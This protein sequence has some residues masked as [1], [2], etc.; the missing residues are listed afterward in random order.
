MKV[1]LASP[2]FKEDELLQYK[3][4]VDLLRNSGDEIFV[5]QEHTIP[6]GEFLP[7]SEWA[8]QVFDMDV[9]ALDSADLVIVLNWGLYSD[10]GTAWEQGYAYAKGKR[11]LSVLMDETKESEYSLMTINGSHNTICFSALFG[12]DNDFT[13]QPTQK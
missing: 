1:Y 4:M 3:Q 5:P 8:R 11:I 12:Y 9:A 6:N 2:F 13:F 10:S 7:N